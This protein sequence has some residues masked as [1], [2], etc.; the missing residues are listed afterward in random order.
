MDSTVHCF[1]VFNLIEVV[2]QLAYR[3]KDI[4]NIFFSGTVISIFS[5][6]VIRVAH[7]SQRAKSSLQSA[8][9]RLGTDND[10][11]MLTYPNK[12]LGAGCIFCYVQTLLQRVSYNIRLLKI[13]CEV[14]L[15]PL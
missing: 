5:R 10:S 14:V 2:S 3:F 12:L 11:G 9:Y 4:I 8:R 6:E 7:Y 1:K 13:R 15:E